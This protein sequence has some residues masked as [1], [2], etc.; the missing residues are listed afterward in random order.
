MMARSDVAK[1]EKVE[2]VR[3]LKDE[4]RTHQRIIVRA[5]VQTESWCRRSLH[6]ESVARSKCVGVL[7][8]ELPFRGFLLCKV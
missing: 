1:A 8:R 6:H 5:T 7:L 2:L 3:E 4:M